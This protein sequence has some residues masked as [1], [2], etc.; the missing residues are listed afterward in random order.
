MNGHKTMDAIAAIS[1]GI[2]IPTGF[3]S[4]ATAVQIVSLIAGL[5]SISWYAYRWYKVYKS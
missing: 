5:L 3:L 4:L 2:S 1:A